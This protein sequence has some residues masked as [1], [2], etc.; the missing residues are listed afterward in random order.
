MKIAL[1]IC[2]LLF[3]S[4][5]W[6]WKVEKEKNKMTD[7]S[8]VMFTKESDNRVWSSRRASLSVLVNCASEKWAIILNHPWVVAGGPVKA[9]IDSDPAKPYYAGKMGGGKGL[10]IGDSSSNGEGNPKTVA[11]SFADAKKVIVQY[12][13][14]GGKSVLAEFTMAGLKKKLESPCK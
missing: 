7:E 12:S 1:C 6:A 9:R 8:H 4:F 10:V 13:E 2:S 14:A 5:S 11:L 3:S